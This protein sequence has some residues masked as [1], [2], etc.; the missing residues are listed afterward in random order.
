M[1]DAVIFYSYTQKPY[2]YDKFPGS[3]AN[4]H[5]LTA[6]SFIFDLQQQQQYTPLL[7][8]ANTTGFGT[9]LLAGILFFNF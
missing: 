6:S 7:L 2:S 5:F 3:Y 9:D 1:F 8:L 4:T